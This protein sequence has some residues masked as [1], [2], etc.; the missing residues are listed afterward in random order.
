[1]LYGEYTTFIIDWTWFINQYI[2]TR[3]S[4]ISAVGYWLNTELI[5]RKKNEKHFVI[6]ISVTDLIRSPN[7]PIIL[8]CE[9]GQFHWHNNSVASTAF[10]PY[11]YKLCEYRRMILK[12]HVDKFGTSFVARININNDDGISHEIS[13][14][15]L[16]AR[17]YW[18]TRCSS[19]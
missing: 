13:T 15:N 12:L 9:K 7:R 17:L 8:W 1:M 11:G 16:Y 5:R 18:Y 14:S 4:G 19:N 3:A 2:Y 10:P 6:V